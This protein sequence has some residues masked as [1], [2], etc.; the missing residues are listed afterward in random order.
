M[1]SLVRPVCVTDQTGSVSFRTP[2]NSNLVIFI[3][4][5]CGLEKNIVMC[6]TECLC[7]LKFLMQ[8]LCHAIYL[9]SVIFI[10]LD[11]IFVIG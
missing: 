3:Y 11:G 9:C 7:M 8:F 5:L 4:F 2:V 6:A 1:V 10:I